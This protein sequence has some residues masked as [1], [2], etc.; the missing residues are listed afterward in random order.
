MVFSGNASPGLTNSVA[1][2][3]GV[4][5]GKI[6]VDRFSDFETRVELLENIRGKSVFIIQSTVAPNDNLIEVLFMADAMRRASAAKIT[7]IVPYFGYARQDRRVRSSRVPIS[8]R[9][10]ADMMSSVRIDHIATVDLHA[11]Q[12]QGFFSMPVDNLYGSTVFLQHFGNME[13]SEDCV[14]VSPDIG[15]VA[16][17]RAVAKRLKGADL[18]IVD[19]RRYGRNRVEVMNIIGDV[20]GKDCILI[21]DIVDTAGTLSKAAK[22]LKDKGAKRVIAYCTHGILSGDAVDN[23][24][25]SPIDELIITNSIPNEEKIQSITI[26]VNTLD[27]SP[28]L[29]EAIR[30]IHTSQSISSIFSDKE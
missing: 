4:P 13:N 14:V 15:G 12:I 26:K 16:R 1:N 21:D 7:L 28:L 25:A 27:L 18:A 30:R 3:L 6:L 20:D 9:V 5:V 10:I 29:A 23:L 19:K 24:N 17:A 11:E 8:A 2:I 22:V